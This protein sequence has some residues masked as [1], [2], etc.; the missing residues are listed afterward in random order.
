MAEQVL[1]DRPELIRKAILVGTGRQGAEGFKD[2]PDVI[3]ENME[4]SAETNLT[5]KALLVLYSHA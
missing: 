3:P 5:S 2:L 1:M 4:Q